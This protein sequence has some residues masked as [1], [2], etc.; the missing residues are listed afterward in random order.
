[1]PT[2]N[3]V[4]LPIVA[5]LMAGTGA[6]A[7][8]VTGPISAPTAVTESA[9]VAAPAA[10]LPV[11]SAKPAEQ[12]CAAQTWPYLDAKCLT[13]VQPKERE[14][15]VVTAPRADDAD[16]SA[17]VSPPAAQQASISPADQLAPRS[18]LTSSN[19]VLYQ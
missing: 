9:P 15:R 3:L 12:P 17:A 7:A 11:E 1:M 13:R 16:G 5:G 4:A 10:A 8:Y 14:V 2:L 6:V 18:G 19:T